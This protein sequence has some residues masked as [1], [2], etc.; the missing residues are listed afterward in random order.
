MPSIS[1]NTLPKKERISGKKSVESLLGSGHWGC[2]AM[3]KYCWLDRSAGSCR[4]VADKEVVS[5]P[6]VMVSV[7]KKFFKRAV[8]RN[9]LKRRM[10]E[11]YRLQ[12]GLL[13][14]TDVDVLFVYNSKEPA[15]YSEIYSAVGH[16]LE[17]IS[18]QR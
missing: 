7:S 4:D 5:G 3:L 9:L 12:K 10:R 18:G 16:I 15:E 1:V 6:R 2:V 8:R 13:A 17:L 14:G 11:S